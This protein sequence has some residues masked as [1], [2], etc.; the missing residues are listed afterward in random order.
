[1][2]FDWLLCFC[3]IRTSWFII[4]RVFV[5]V[6]VVVFRKVSALP[7][8]FKVKMP[9]KKKKAKILAKT[10]QNFKILNVVIPLE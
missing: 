1:M 8:L 7:C 3:Y 9:K 6:V 2:L 5:V 4:L 10:S